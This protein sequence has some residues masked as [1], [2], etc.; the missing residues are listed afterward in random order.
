[1]KDI[2]SKLMFNILKNSHEL[3]NGLP[4][5]TERI[6]IENVKKLVTN[7]LD[8]TEHAIQIKN[9]EQALNHELTLKK[10]YRVIKFNQKS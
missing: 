10:V 5:L 6:K 1:M 7:L 8:K 3:H 9:S 2:F 4:F